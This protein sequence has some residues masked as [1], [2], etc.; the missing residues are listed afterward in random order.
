[1]N[2]QCQSM[3]LWLHFQAGF[4]LPWTHSLATSALNGSGARNNCWSLPHILAI[5][6]T[7]LLRVPILDIIIWSPTS[8][9]L[10]DC[11]LPLLKKRSLSRKV[12]LSHKQPAVNWNGEFKMEEGMLGIETGECLAFLQISGL[13]QS[14]RRNVNTTFAFLI[15]IWNGTMVGSWKIEWRALIIMSVKYMLV[16][17][18]RF[19]SRS[20]CCNMVIVTHWSV[21]SIILRDWMLRT[22]SE[23]GWAPLHTQ[24]EPKFHWQRSH[25][26]KFL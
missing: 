25:L 12:L 6:S 9:D 13:I 11:M 17:L 18:G 1:M 23:I 4:H 2:Q 10:W 21:K 14:N 5:A 15:W 3:E 16:H 20:Y 19:Q 26:Q 8:C 7:H 24:H 22:C